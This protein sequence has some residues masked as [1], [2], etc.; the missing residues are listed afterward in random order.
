VAM[1][2]PIQVVAGGDVFR[3][4]S[5]AHFA[6]P[7]SP[8]GSLLVTHEQILKDIAGVPAP[9][10]N[11]IRRA[12]DVGGNVD[13]RVFGIEGFQASRGMLDKTDPFVR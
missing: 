12:R 3:G 7:T 4:M 2:S 6:S 5:V 10:P 8:R 1:G 11:L 9:S 13:I